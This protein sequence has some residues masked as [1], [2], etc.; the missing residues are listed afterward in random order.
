MKK[1]EIFEPAMCCPTGLCGVGVDPELLRVSTVLDTLEKKDIK[2]E[3]Y[4]L[5][6]A[7]QAFVINQS[8]NQFIKDNGVE[9]L[10]VLVVDGEIVI[11]GR[12]PSN[13]E[14]ST[15]LDLPEDTLCKQMETTEV[16]DESD[17]CC[18]S[19]GCCCQ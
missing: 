2:V 5:T 4:N 8:V 18:C 1:L 7:P 13:E 17:D 19:G 9:G 15:L 16:K 11:T 12:Y 14:F 3:R 6:N 10:P